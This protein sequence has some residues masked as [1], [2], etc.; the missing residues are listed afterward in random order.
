MAVLWLYC[1]S[2]WFLGLLASSWRL[3]VFCKNI[4]SSQKSH[5]NATAVV[6]TS[7]SSISS[8]SSNSSNSR[9]QTASQDNSDNKNRKDKKYHKKINHCCQTTLALLHARVLLPNHCFIYQLKG[10]F[11]EELRGR[12]W[13][14]PPLATSHDLNLAFTQLHIHSTSHPRS[15]TITS[16]SHSLNLT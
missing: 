1:D 9:S 16:A 13:F 5:N 10:S 3:G 12:D 2:L 6:T 8:N 4:R 14:S 11:V 7:S 15:L